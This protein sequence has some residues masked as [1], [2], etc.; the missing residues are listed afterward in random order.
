[1][2]KKASERWHSMSAV[3]FE[4]KNEQ[5]VKMLVKMKELARE[6]YP[7]LVQIRRTLHENPELG[8]EEFAT[9]RLIADHMEKLGLEVQREVA[10]TG[11]VALLRGAFP[12]KTVGIR[13]DMDALPIQEINEVPYK[14]KKPGK[15]HA[16]GHDVHVTSAIGAAKILSHFREEMTGNVKFIFQPAEESTGGAKPM[17]DAGVLENPKVDAIIGGHVWGSLESGIVEVLPGP[18]MASSDIIHLTIRGKGGHAAH[19]QATIDPV[20]IASEIVVA[21]Q[22]IVSRQMDPFEPVVISICMFR[23]GDV[24][25]VIPHSAYLEGAV[26]TLNNG[27]RK[28]LAQKIEDIIRGITQPYGATYELDYSFGYPVTVNDPAVTEIVRNSAVKV[29]GTDKVRIAERA[30]M[31]AEDFAYFL[32]EVPG[33]YVRIG[34]RNPEKGICHDIHHPQFDIDEAV[35]ELTP[36]VYAQAAFDLLTD[37]PEKK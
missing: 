11:V 5:L 3:N 4:N 35:L 15:M 31:G 36:V 13:A 33:T 8:F 14:S 30:S 28:E 32:L 2:Q 12:G 17:V 19:P 1:M 21:L 6:Q 16:C 34:T 24:F 27:L 23:A 18:I 29:L 20:I 22:K 26:R 25:N 9:A 37:V 10:G 7:E